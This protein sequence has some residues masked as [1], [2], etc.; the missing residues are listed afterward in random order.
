[1][2]IQNTFLSGEN[3]VEQMVGIAVDET[4]HKMTHDFLPEMLSLETRKQLQQ[5]F[6]PEASE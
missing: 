4:L 5:L 2:R 1:V 6:Q 3:P